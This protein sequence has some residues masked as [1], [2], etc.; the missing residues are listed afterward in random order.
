MDVVVKKNK[1]K[2]AQHRKMSL[3]Q[4]HCY[5]YRWFQNMKLEHLVITSKWYQK[6]TFQIVKV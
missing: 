2:E 4:N 1:E 5:P 6:K 3:S